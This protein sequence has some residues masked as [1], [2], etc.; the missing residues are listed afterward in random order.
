[1]ATQIIG[2]T[3]IFDGRQWV[4]TVAVR[5]GVLQPA[6]GCP[7]DHAIEGVLFPGFVNAHAHLDL[8]FTL[9]PGPFYQWV[10]RLIDKIFHEYDA[11][12]SIPLSLK[13]LRDSGVRYVGDIARRPQADRLQEEIF[14]RS[15]YEF[16]VRYP[17]ISEEGFYSPHSL[18]TVPHDFL[19]RFGRENR[20]RFQIHL[21]ESRDEYEYFIRGNE[22]F[23]R[24]Y[25]QKFSRERF[26]QPYRSPVQVLDDLGLLGP[27]SILVHMG[28]AT[29]EDLDLV[30]RAGA[31]VIACPESNRFLGNAVA[32][33]RGL[34][35]RGIP[36]GI[37]T[38]GKCSRHALDFLED[39]HA[40]A[41]VVGYESAF[42]AATSG[43][44]GVIGL[45]DAY[46]LYGQPV[47]RAVVGL[48]DGVNINRVKSLSDVLAG[49]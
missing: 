16:I 3:G 39:Y 13:L 21:A 38:D 44:A 25:L 43:G 35:E 12:F 11:D 41:G 18:Y 42:R 31:S 2:A 6:G 47:S 15:F 20:Q 48:G 26:G 46:S 37:G 40:V 23:Y 10:Q 30:Q 34:E 19:Q 36:Y 28:E 27:L 17:D 8:Y 5:D 1:M 33:L 4:Q 32:D 22:T 29:G 7:A 9:E 14:V 45:G 24:E 49:A